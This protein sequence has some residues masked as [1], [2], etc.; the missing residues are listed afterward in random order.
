[1][2]ELRTA[3]QLPPVAWIGNLGGVGF[4]YTR[5]LR[6]VGV[7]GDL[8]LP[9]V[10]L[11]RARQGNPEHEFPGAGRLEFLQPYRRDVLNHG[12]NRL[13][14]L[15]FASPFE[16]RIGSR[17][18]L[19]Q[20]QTCNEVAALRIKRRYGVPY[21]GMTTGADLSEVA[22][23]TSRYS[24]LYRRALSEAEHV[25]LVNVD[26]YETL[27]R[28]GLKLKSH[29]FLPFCVDLERLQPRPNPWS[30]PIV[31]FCA[32]RLDWRDRER[33]SVKAN[34]V[35]FR[36]LADCLR[37]QRER[38]VGAV[39]FEVRVADWGPDREA[40]RDLVRTLGIKDCVR[41]VPFGDKSVFYENVEQA[42]IVIDQFSL[43]AT[44]LTAIE[45][46]AL[47]RPVMA[48][49]K[50]NLAR[51]A[52]GAPMPVMNCANAGEVRDAL[53]GLSPDAL[54]DASRASGE[55]VTT[56]HSDERIL[57]ILIEVYGGILG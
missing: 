44:G 14:R 40:T 46:M 4:N 1:V 2:T 52:Y 47:G 24:Q 13:G 51:R 29:G 12:L 31:L 25:F 11:K 23:G 53:I 41:F 5:L 56:H 43:G 7:D 30:E 8:Y 34:D 57:G 6:R 42:N 39:R 15:G 33:A 36:G 35:F 17:Y 19:V 18:G 48:F 38:G 28:T 32:A 55:W 37:L 49:V 21:V 22:T 54:A 16:R 45:A 50:E 20:A 27:A 26:Q 3:A 9:R 10:Y